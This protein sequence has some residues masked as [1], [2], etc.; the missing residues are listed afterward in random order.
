MET[1][2]PA[3]EGTPPLWNLK[4]TADYLQCSIRHVQNLQKRGLP[5][6]L[7][8]RLSRFDPTE[9]REYLLRTRGVR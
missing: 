6:I 9:V 4:Q 3:R 2:T 1:Q 8:G 5:F 7:V